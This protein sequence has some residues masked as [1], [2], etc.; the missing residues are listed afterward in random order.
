MAEGKDEGRRGKGDERIR[1]SAGEKGK[2]L[3]M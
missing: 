3:Y 2:V 1:G